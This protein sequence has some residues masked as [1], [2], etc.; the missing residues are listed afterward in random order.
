MTPCWPTVA[1]NHVLL[2]R[3]RET[4]RA[5]CLLVAVLVIFGL[6]CGALPGL[7]GAGFDVAAVTAQE[8]QQP[9]PQQPEYR[10]GRGEYEMVLIH[11]LGAN[12]SIW[13][14]VLPYL[15]GTFKVW[16]YELHGH[17]TTRPMPDPTIAKE[18]AALGQFLVDNDIPRP[19]LVGHGMGGLIAMRF[20]LDNPRDVERL[21]IIDAAPK[22]LATTADKTHVAESLLKDYDRFVASRYLNYSPEA[23]LS[24]HIVDMALRTDSASFISLVMSSFDFDL[25]DDLSRQAI[26]ILVIG[27]AMFFPHPDSNAQALDSMGYAAARTISFKRVAQTGHY[28]MLERP[29]YLASIL[30][31]FGAYEEFR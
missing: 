26:P 9:E 13:D 7:S 8:Q 1:T 4:G 31:A 24:D 29:V 25:T 2:N 5:S 10:E 16:T 18:A 17:G 6:S 28:I 27:S 20:A 14:D 11:G 30:L 19:V 23:E 15:R 22:Q 12:A 21:V 3:R